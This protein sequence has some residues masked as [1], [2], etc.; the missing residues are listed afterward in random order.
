MLNK[1]REILK[2]A[3]KHSVKTM[4]QRESDDWPPKCGIILY[5]PHRPKKHES[6][7]KKR[8]AR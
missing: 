2:N 5:Q 7:E 6:I 1:E 3:L 4:V 8:A